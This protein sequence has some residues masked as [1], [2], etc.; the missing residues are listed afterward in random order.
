MDILCLR[1]MRFEDIAEVLEIESEC[2]LSPWTFAGYVEAL[3]S[4]ETMLAVAETA[5]TIAGF[6][7]MRLITP[8]AEILNLGV[9]K[10]FRRSGIG[11]KLLQAAISE[12]EQKEVG[13]IWLEV[14]QSNVRAQA[15]YRANGFEIVGERKNFYR[16]P[17]ENAFLMRAGL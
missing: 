12:A 7:C 16:F 14:R 5:E 1:R 13:K 15:F 6:I 10:R 11:K 4:S 9:K 8:E 2:E 17:T 3:K